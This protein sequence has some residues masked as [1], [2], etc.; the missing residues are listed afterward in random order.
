MIMSNVDSLSSKYPGLCHGFDVVSACLVH[1]DY[2]SDWLCFRLHL[3]GMSFSVAV[4][5][6]YWDLR[7]TMDGR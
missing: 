7:T 5:P 4:S 1:W 2:I 6:G 3:T